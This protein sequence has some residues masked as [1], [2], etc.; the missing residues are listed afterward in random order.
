MQIH[1]HA[2]P[3]EPEPPFAESPDAVVVAVV[4]YT[5]KFIINGSRTRLKVRQIIYLYI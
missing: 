3:D 4:G 5:S 2:E 1:V